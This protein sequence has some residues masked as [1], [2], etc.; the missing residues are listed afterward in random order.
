M[1]VKIHVMVFWLMILCSLID[2]HNILKEHNASVLRVEVSQVGKMVCYVGAGRKR[3]GSWRMCVMRA[4][5]GEEKDG[6]DEP[7]GT[8]SCKG[9]L[10]H[11]K[12]E[13][14]KKQPFYMAW[15]E[16]G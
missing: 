9:K 5:N 7:M 2:G 8:T 6:T 1:M 14:R 3:N 10:L 4:M 16:G 15:K 12:K 11:D 13:K